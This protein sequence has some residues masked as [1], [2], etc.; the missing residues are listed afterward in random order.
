MKTALLYFHTIIHLR[1]IQIYYRI[2]YKIRTIFREI[3]SF[4]Y[5][6][7]ILTKSYPINLKTFIPSNQSYYPEQNCFQFLNQLQTFSDNK[8]NWNDEKTFGKLWA[9][10]LNYFDFL[11]QE[12]LTQIQGIALIREYIQARPYLKTGLESF[13]TSFRNINWI[14]FLSKYQIHDPEIDVFLMAQYIRL[15][16][17]LEYHLMGNHLLENA[18]SLLFGGFYFKNEGFLLSANKI[19]QKELPEQILADGGHF[20]RSPMYHQI[21]LFRI[22]DCLNLVR[23]NEGFGEY[24][25][26]KILTFYAQKMLNFLQNVTFRNGDIPLVNDAVNNIAPTTKQIL[27]YAKQLN[28]SLQETKLS[29][30]GYR[31]FENNTFELFMDVGDIAP[32]YQPA[33]A[34]SDTLSFLLYIHEKPFIVDTGTSTYENNAIRQ[35]ERSTAAHNTVQIGDFEQSEMWAIFRVGRRAKA[36]ILSENEHQITASHDGYE[37]FGIT[38]ER[39]YQ[40]E[41]QR[42]IIMDRIIGETNHP[43]KTYLHFHPNIEMKID[44]NIIK[45]S[46]GKIIFENVIEIKQSEYFF[47]EQFNQRKPAI[48]LTL[49]FKKHLT[50]IIRYRQPP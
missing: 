26:D 9:Y 43:Q 49:L 33:H 8:I 27:E 21:T 37:R 24:N 4:K 45:T 42:V 47:C 34:H 15:G 50:T 20:E 41:N 6:K 16:D 19:F 31:K 23:N 48:M 44:G 2:F 32:D 22:L 12:N 14:K 25:F 39:T 40:I 13:P 36:K 29:E 30:S 3:I 7:L 28:I 10:N 1:P 5:P 35:S 46:L 17:N 38:Y 11:N 18:F